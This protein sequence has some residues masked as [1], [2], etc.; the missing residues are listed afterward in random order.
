LGFPRITSGVYPTSA[1]YESLKREL[2]DGVEPAY[3]G[4]VIEF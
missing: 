3:D 2:P 1:Y 4:M